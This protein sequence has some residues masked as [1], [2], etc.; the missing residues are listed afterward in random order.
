MEHCTDCG[1]CC[2]LYDHHCDMLNVCVTARNFKYF[3]L[4]FF[5]FA[6]KLLIIAGSGF[7]LKGRF[8]ESLKIRI[9]EEFLFC[10]VFS[11]IFGIIFFC[12][13]FGF[14]NCA[15]PTYFADYSK[16]V[17]DNMDYL[18]F[19]YRIQYKK[20]EKEVPSNLR[21]FCHYYFGSQWNILRWFVPF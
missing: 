6:I 21:L 7:V 20:E 5:H 1:T 15:A 4:F 12:V 13:A 3:F 11:I 19:L 8:K 10:Q 14:L 17:E 9:G 16:E 2:E 18:R